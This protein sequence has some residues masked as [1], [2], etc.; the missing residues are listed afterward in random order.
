[1]NDVSV[2]HFDALYAGNPDPWNVAGSWYEQRKIALLMAALPK[3]RY[4]Y[5]YEPACGTGELSA[6]LARRCDRLLASDASPH[7]VEA[8]R[9]RTASL[10]SVEVALHRLPNDWPAD[11]AKFDLVVVSELGY[12]LKA[13]ALQQLALR[14]AASLQP[15]GTLVACHSL[16]PFDD[17]L[18]PTPEVHAILSA[19]LS[20]TSYRSSQ[21]LPAMRAVVQHDEPEFR[22]EV[23]LAPETTS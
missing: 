8:A 9:A 3:P 6:R 5:A 20:R 13:G 23:W 15:G 2:A 1:M 17:R 21:G 22:L 11:D 18:R 16:L 4:A 12:Y 19:A 14:C 7:A 10:S